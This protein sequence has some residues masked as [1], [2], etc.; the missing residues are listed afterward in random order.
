MFFPS[1]QPVLRVVGI[2]K[3]FPGVLALDD[4]SLELYPGEIHSLL[5]ENG[6]GKST[7]AKIMAGIYVPDRGSI[8]VSGRSFRFL[9]PVKAVSYG[10]V[11]IPQSPSLVERLTVAENILIA[12]RSYGILSSMGRVKEAVARRAREMG[13]GIDPEAEVGKLSY[14]QKQIVELLKASLLDAKVL[15]LDEVT[16]YLPRPLREAFYGYLRL[17]RS[18]GRTILLITHKVFE[19]IE[20]ADRITVM[21]SGRIVGTVERSEFDADLVRGL[22]FGSSASLNHVDYLP[23]GEPPRGPT[24]ERR[25]VIL[26]DD[27]WAVGETGGHALRGVSVEVNPGE[28]L[29]VVGISGNGQRELA[30]VLVGLRPVERGRYYLDGI[31]VTNKG[32]KAI[33]ASG[34]GFVPEAPLYYSLSGDLSLMEN[35]ALAEQ[36]GGPVLSLRPLA[37]RVRELIEKY[38]IAAASPRTQAKVLSGGNVMRFTIARELESAKKALVALNPTRSL[39]ERFALSFVK[40]L[41]RSSRLSGLSV[42]YISESLDEVLRVSDRVAVINSGRIVGV[43]SREAAERETLEKLMVM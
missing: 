12:L 31:D 21:R 42:V 34:V 18:E 30:E 7:L 26:L 5:G 38:G 35:L 8:E 33:R 41:R 29:G 10:I 23:E 27:V 25:P 32:A 37:A 9:D 39:D 16:T 11:Y 14:T 28:I 22:M 17:L 43:Y 15:L 2:T 13:I 19:A 1:S 6:S 3:R 40:A 20:V 4:V 24:V 36:G